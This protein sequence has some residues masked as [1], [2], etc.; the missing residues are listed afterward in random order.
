MKK[1]GFIY[2]RAAHGPFGHMCTACQKEGICHTP[3][4]QL[5]LFLLLH[6]QHTT[7]QLHTMQQQHTTVTIDAT[8][9]TM[10]DDDKGSCIVWALVCLFFLLDWL[11]TNMF[12]IP[13]TNVLIG[14]N[15]HNNNNTRHDGCPWHDKRRPRRCNCIVWATVCFFKN[16]LLLHLTNIFIGY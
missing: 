12:M 6:W 7:Q 13:L 5:S 3:P 10:Q 2:P 15:Y 11:F 14:S 4:R 9:W 16:C 8:S 1:Q